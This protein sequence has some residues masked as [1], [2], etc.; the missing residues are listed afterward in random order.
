VGRELLIVGA[1]PG[2]SL[3]SARRFG[4]EGYRVHLLG[5]SQERL[6]GL[7]DV[8]AAEG[9]EAKVHPADITDHAALTALVENLDRE[10]PL[11][12]CIFQ[13][14]GRSGDLVDVLDATVANVRDNLELLVLGAVAV[15]AALAGPM[16]GRGSGTLVFVGGGS[17]RL[18]LRDFGNLGMAMAGLRNYALTLNAAL[19]GTGAHAAFYT[20]AGMIATATPEPGQLDPQELAA[21][22][23]TLVEEQ[24]AREVLM[25]PQGEIVPKGAR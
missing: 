9:T 3:A 14:G 20:V 11:D 25:T 1:G 22:M 2:L 17:A 16:A 12:A 15:G 8:L 18:P 7:R 19:S 4:A 21:R 24:D 10:T 5:R 6:E 13:P 23:W